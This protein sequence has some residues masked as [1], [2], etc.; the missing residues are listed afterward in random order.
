MRP[1]L[2]FGASGFLGAHVRAALQPHAP[3]LCPGRDRCDLLTAGAV[4]L[5]A[6]LRATGAGTVVNCTGRLDGSVADL[7]SANTMVTAK[8]IDAVER[9]DPTIRLV[10]LGSAGEYGPV[11]HGEAATEDGPATPVSEY[12][13][14]HLAATT[15]LAVASRRHRVD[16]VTLRVFNPVGTGQRGANLLGRAAE[17]MAMA[18]ATGAGSIT[19]GPLTSHRDFVD[20]RDVASA[21]LAVVTAPYLPARVVNIGSGRAVATRDAVELLARVAGFRGEVREEYVGSTRS[22]GVDW[23][24]ADIER[25]RDTIGWQ[26]VWRLADTVETIWA[27][28]RPVAQGS[29]R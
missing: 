10:R 7:V 17:R 18:L 11:P 26:P 19:L 22:A 13:V 27:E 21:V 29:R 12:G 8:L 4:E 16:G 6:R 28:Q 23:M 24:L 5:A 9:V 20:A 14:S 1:V 15:L 25:A 3:L 2:L